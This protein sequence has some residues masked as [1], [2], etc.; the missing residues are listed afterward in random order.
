MN[1]KWLLPAVVFI[2]AN[3]VGSVVGGYLA[4]RYYCDITAWLGR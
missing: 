3:L 2:F 4:A 1:R